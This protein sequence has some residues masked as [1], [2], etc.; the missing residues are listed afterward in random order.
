MKT[1]KHFFT[2]VP[3]AFLLLSGACSRDCDRECLV[4]LMD[5]YLEAVVANNPSLVPL[6]DSVAFVENTE[7]LSVGEGLWIFANDVLASLAHFRSLRT[8]RWKLIENINDLAE[9]YDMQ[10]D[11]NETRNLVAECP[12][13]V[14]KMKKRLSRRWL[15][16]N[17]DW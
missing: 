13:K 3:V 7:Q 10:E 12:E 11:P 15:E 16:G 1:P 2:C 6:A 8:Q 5:F 9:L 4:A 17:G 14:G